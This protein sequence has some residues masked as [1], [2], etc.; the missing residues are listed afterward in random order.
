MRV[1]PSVHQAYSGGSVMSTLPDPYDLNRFA[2]AQE[3]CYLQVMA[4]LRAG[5]KQSHWSWF[6][7]P[8]MR[9]LGASPVSLRYAIGSL[10]EARAYLAHPL[11]GARL[12]EC[13]AALNAHRAQGQGPSAAAMLGDIDA[14]KIRSC[15]TLF[16]EA[17]GAESAQGRTFGEA[18][19][20]FFGGQPDE[21]TLDILGKPQG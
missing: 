20:K 16:R 10:E 21:A 14:R 11:L 9:G 4:E 1:L 5:R 15:A 12:I 18:L 17:A 7:L 13:V 2:Q 19:R 6:I 3:P 8:Q